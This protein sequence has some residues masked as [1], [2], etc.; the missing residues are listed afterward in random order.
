VGFF[1]KYSCLENNNG[2]TGEGWNERIMRSISCRLFIFIFNSILYCG[3][4]LKLYTT[5]NTVAE[6]TTVRL[7]RSH[8]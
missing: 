6:F 1:F 7:V 4:Y 5:I 2:I 8:V 3:W